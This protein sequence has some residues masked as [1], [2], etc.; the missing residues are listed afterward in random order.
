MTDKPAEEAIGKPKL[1]IGLM[2]GTSLDGID[3]ALLRTDG[4]TIA[5]PGLAKSFP[6][7]RAV[8]VFVRRAIKAALE[9][10]DSAKDI[11][12]AERAVTT[13][14]VSAVK[15]L[16]DDAGLSSDDVD[17]IGFHGQT[18]F[19]RSPRASFATS[20][21]RIGRT[22]QIG[23][24]DSLARE[25][26]IATV[27]DFRTADIN[28]GG[29]GAP[30]APVYHATLAKTLSENG[31]G[32]EATA[33]LNIGGVANVTFVPS[34]PDT[35][36]IIAFDCGPGNGLL[37]QWMEQKTGEAIDR[38]G[39]ASLAG[40]VDEDILRLMLRNPFLKQAPPKSLDR[41]DFKLD[42]VMAL[43]M[44][45]GAATLTAFTAACIAST[46]SFL[47]EAPS[48]WIVC[49]GGRRNPA[50]MAALA[51]RLNGEVQTAE[52]VGW[53]GDDV[54]AEC[55]AY[56]AVR[57]LQG[58]PISFPGTTGVP[59]PLTGGVLHYAHG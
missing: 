30:L 2:S 47:P 18:I 13:A 21:H 51:D 10:R 28:A 37:D 50:M 43:S 34:D 33:V 26:G 56:L 54:E 5:E 22:W 12:D 52:D 48:R 4:E 39:K 59:R 55:F 15:S 45:D 1:A 32:E 49:G 38:D 35:S 31:G 11:A 20:G 42:P 24:G 40:T 16:L 9:G 7:S 25:T 27:S 46:T 8:K 6:Y 29:E 36:G 19:H 58:L 14:H 41:Y 57:S 17:V 44:F 53:R 3:A 23:S